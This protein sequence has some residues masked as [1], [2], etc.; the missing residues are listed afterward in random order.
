MAT[1]E[2]G[3]MLKPREVPRPMRGK[4]RVLWTRQTILRRTKEAKALRWSGKSLVLMSMSIARFARSSGHGG[5]QRSLAGGSWAPS[6]AL[7]N[8]RFGWIFQHKLCT[9]F[10]HSQ[11][12]ARLRRRM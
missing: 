2:E 10:L 12:E 1:V 3:R 7:G 9:V 6:P 5:T 11:S 8:R 4:A